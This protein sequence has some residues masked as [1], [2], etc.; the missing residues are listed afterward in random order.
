MTILKDSDARAHPAYEDSIRTAVRRAATSPE[1][2]FTVY[3]D[4]TAVFVRASYA[5]RPACSKVVCIAQRWDANAVQL[6]FDGARSE[7]VRI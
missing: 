1:E 7:W 4:G 3:W 6:R 5:P 2:S